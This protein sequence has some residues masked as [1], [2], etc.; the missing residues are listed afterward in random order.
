MRRTY[1]VVSSGE[2]V[3]GLLACTLLAAKGLSCLH[4]DTSPEKPGTFLWPDTPL[5]VTETFS[6]GVME[7]L[8]A[9]LEP[10]MMRSLAVKHVSAGQWADTGALIPI[11]PV[12]AWA[13]RSREKS[14][15]KDYLSLLMK[16]LDKPRHLWRELSQGARAGLPWQAALMDAFGSQDAGRVAYLHGLAAGTGMCAMEYGNMK[17]VLG[18][19]LKATNGD[20]VETP[21]AE[22]MI[23]GKET[24]GLALEG[25][26]YKA[27]RYLTEELP[28]RLQSDGFFLHGQCEAS[29]AEVGA[30]I[31]E[32]LLVVPP[33]DDLDFPLILWAT[34][35]DP[36]TKIRFFTRITSGN[37]S[38]MS[39]TEI[40][41][42]A[43]G[44]VYK[45]LQRVLFT[46]EGTLLGFETV[47]VIA[48]D[49]VR[50]YFRFS[51]SV[52]APSIFTRR[53]YISP[54]ENL[55]ACDRDK[56]SFLGADG[57]LFWGICIANAVLRDLRRSDLVT[58]KPA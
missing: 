1:D 51:D 46:M 29:G 38:L 30:R 13:G 21:G 23:S 7:P 58:I 16:S 34:R 25:V 31:G 32:Q 15:N 44:M 41:S 43:S 19:R 3:A 57:E 33:P 5:L 6:R 53:H 14:M 42:W 26:T 24:L 40:F 18:A 35:G 22:L 37:D 28:G 49:T 50:P 2:G 52:R 36:W 55:Y 12:R 10:R 48:D 8:L 56:Y 4:V 39:L 54:R 11:D 17:A 9:T 45:L 47:N 20:C 27:H